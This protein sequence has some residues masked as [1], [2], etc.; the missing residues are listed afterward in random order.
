MQH[1]MSI[2][3]WTVIVAKIVVYDDKAATMRR[4]IAA[5]YTTLHNVV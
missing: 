1:Y 2:K 5:D 3:L 4:C